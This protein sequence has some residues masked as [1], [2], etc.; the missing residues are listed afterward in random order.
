MLGESDFIMRRHPG[1]RFKGDKRSDD[2][3]FILLR[4]DTLPSDY[5][6]E[7]AK[8]YRSGDKEAQDS[9]KNVTAAGLGGDHLGQNGTQVTYVQGT[10]TRDHGS[11]ILEIQFPNDQGICN[12]D[13]G[14]P[15]FLRIGSGVYLT[16]LSTAGYRKSKLDEKNRCSAALLANS[17]T[18]DR[19]AW[20]NRM[21]D[22]D[23]RSFKKNN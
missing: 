19:L 12:G 20:V 14:G 10:I 4:S 6:F 16:A 9:E 11:G 2:I 23:R 21:A 5:G 17:I 8:I 18:P 7:T 15:V 22:E 1:F 3:A 13:S